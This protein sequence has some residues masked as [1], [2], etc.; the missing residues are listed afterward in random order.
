[1]FRDLLSDLEDFH[2][3]HPIVS[4]AVI[5]IVILVICSLVAN[6]FSNATKGS[7]VITITKEERIDKGRN[8]YY[9][10]WGIDENENDVVYKIDDVIL[11]GR[12]NSSDIYGELKVGK[13][14]SIKYDGIRFGLFSW[15]K[16]IYEIE[17]V[18]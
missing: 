17:E 6:I 12:W 15:Y 18:K 7:D 2:D 5:L 8:H 1:M 16:N 10:V 3:D 11:L 13:T 4:W 14:Y 9:L